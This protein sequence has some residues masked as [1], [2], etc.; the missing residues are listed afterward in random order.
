MLT[1]Y[2]N[3]NSNGNWISCI[4]IKKIVLENHT[5]LFIFDYPIN[6]GVGN[7]KKILGSPIVGAV[8]LVL[9]FANT[10]TLI[11]ESAYAWQCAT[12]SS[13]ASNFNGTPIAGGNYIWF[14]SV[15]KLKS[16][17]PPGGLTIK[18]SDQ[19]I[20]LQVS[21]TT[22]ITLHP[23]KA[24]I[25]FSPTATEATTHYNT[26]T[27]TWETTVPAGFG[28]NVFLS[29]LTFQVPAGGLP[30][31]IN[32]V[33]WSGN[34]AAS[35]SASVE[36]QWGAAV[37]TSPFPNDHYN[38]IGV[39]PVHSTSLDAYHN[40]DQAGTPENFKAYVIGGARGG[41]GSNWTGSYSATAHADFGPCS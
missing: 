35:D 16:P 34:F 9:L 12:Q 25:T 41:G 10:S 11:P 31:G 15:F 38:T 39:K 1:E 32:P 40:G 22:T 18:F 21:S 36:W 37:Y 13:I 14:N 3:G 17:V 30:G 4:C 6:N 2:Y 33:T 19:A 20:V 23:H 29:G 27:N 28:D 5:I 7:L 8:A 24:I 26:V